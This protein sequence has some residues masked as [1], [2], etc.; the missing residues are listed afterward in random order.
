MDPVNRETICRLANVVSAEL[1][2]LIRVGAVTRGHDAQNFETFD[3]VATCET[4]HELRSKAMLRANREAITGRAC[5]A[6]C[7]LNGTRLK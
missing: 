7:N 4:I 1:D 2:E 6:T 3:A 5:A